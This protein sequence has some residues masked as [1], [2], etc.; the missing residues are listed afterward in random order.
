MTGSA[1]LRVLPRNLLAASARVLAMT[2]RR[3]A[4]DWTSVA[5]WLRGAIVPRDDLPSAP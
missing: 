5:T 2:V 4:A 3:L 1:A